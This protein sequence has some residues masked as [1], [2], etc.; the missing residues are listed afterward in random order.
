[1]R[2][3]D[4]DRQLSTLEMIMCFLLPLMLFLSCFLFLERFFP[5]YFL[6]SF[7]S[8]T[9]PWH[10]TT[11]TVAGAYTNL[12]HSQFLELQLAKIVKRIGCCA[13]LHV[14]SKPEGSATSI[15]TA[16]TCLICI[17]DHH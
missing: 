6:S 8:A 2:K 4:S 13:S 5:L 14:H 16:G 7:L 15:M 9:V 10:H 1:M 12:M 3:T 11:V 17:T